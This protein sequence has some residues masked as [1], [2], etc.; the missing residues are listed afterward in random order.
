VL[1]VRGADLRRRRDGSEYLKLTLGDRSGSVSAVVREE[2]AAALRSSPLP[3]EPEN[4][5]RFFV[6]FLSA[7]PT[8]AAIQAIEAQSFDPDKIW[9]SGQEAYL[10]CPAGAA[11]TR[12]TNAFIEKRLGVS[13]TSR[14]WNTVTKLVGLT[15]G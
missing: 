2:L 3:G 13:A 10:W 8:A 15:G 12:L 6:A 7:R 14:N 11:D 4:P 1:L 9:V 5:S